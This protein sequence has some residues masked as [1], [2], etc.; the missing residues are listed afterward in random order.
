MKNLII[1]G[2]VLVFSF[3]IHSQNILGIWKGSA[4]INRFELPLIF[5][6][7]SV[8]QTLK[9]SMDS[10]KQG[11]KGIPVDQITFN[12]PNISLQIN[13]IRFKYKG[14]LINDSIVGQIEQNGMVIPLNLYKED[15]LKTF[16]EIPKLKIQEPTPPFKY[17]TEDVIFENEFDNIQLAGTLTLPSKKSKNLTAII[18]INGSGPQNRDCEVFGHKPFLVLADYFTKNGYAVF[19]FDD[20]GV[21]LS[22][23]TMKNCTSEDFARDVE[24]AIKYLKTRKEI[25][26]KKIGLVG[27][28]EGGMI[29]QIIASKNQNVNF[30]ILL[31]APGV[32]GKELFI[33]Q[34]MLIGEALGIEKNEISRKSRMNREIYDLILSTKDTILLKNEFIKLYKEYEDSIPSES[35]LISI[36]NQLNSNWFRYF[37]GY[38]PSINLSNIKCPI[39]ALNG[40]KDLQVPYDPNLLEIEKILSAINHSNYKTIKIEGVNHLFQTC[41]TGSP[42]EYST[43][44]ETFSKK[45]MNEMLKW[46]KKI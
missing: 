19:R 3:S 10:P 44:E 46:L 32:V 43:I 34:N 45:T 8:N 40:D 20:R 35:E 39:L 5:H 22:S 6:I 29:A 18:L 9:A 42:E 38:D 31:A 23:G 7:D 36:L 15:T 4:T 28:S 13:S 2:L 41:T 25:N 17:Y 11:A 16:I 37:L 12:N 30:I 21:G 33:Q 27:H 14:Q 24:S 26:P 1:T